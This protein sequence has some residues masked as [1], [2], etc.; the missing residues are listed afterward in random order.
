MAMNAEET[1][2]LIAGGDTFG[3]IH[4]TGDPSLVGP[5]PESGALEDQG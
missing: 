5:E 3:K 4:G 1:V 2:A